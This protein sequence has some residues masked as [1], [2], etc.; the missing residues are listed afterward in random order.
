MD[1]GVAVCEVFPRQIVVFRFQVVA[2]SRNRSLVWRLKGCQ[3]R[4]LLR[5]PYRDEHT[6]D[7]QREQDVPT[8]PDVL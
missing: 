8:S 5:F 6:T 7:Y 2:I 3:G 4:Y 1:V